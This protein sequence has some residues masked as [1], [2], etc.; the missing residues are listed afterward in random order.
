MSKKAQFSYEFDKNL[1]PDYLAGVREIFTTIE[2]QPKII[3]KNASRYKNQRT[4]KD[5]LTNKIYHESW[6]KQ[7]IRISPED[8]Y[9]TVTNVE[10]GRLDIISTRFYGTPRFWWVI[11]MANNIIDPFDIPLGT[12]LRIPVKQSLYLIGGVLS[13]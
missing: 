13:G 5:T 4:I 8:S 7:Y 6:D 10:I 2:Y 9:F 3:Y 12:T 11:A 1:S